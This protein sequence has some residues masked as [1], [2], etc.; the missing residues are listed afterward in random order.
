MQTEKKQQACK[1]FK[2]FSKVFVRFPRIGQF[3]LFFLRFSQKN[4]R[5]KFDIKSCEN[6]TPG[7]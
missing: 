4:R 1:H 7:E 6:R 3:K 5:P 2:E